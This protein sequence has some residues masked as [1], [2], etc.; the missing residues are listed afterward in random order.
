MSIE[1]ITQQ[2]KDCSNKISEVSDNLSELEKGAKLLG[3]QQLADKLAAEKW[4]L[5]HLP[6][7]MIHISATVTSEVVKITEESSRN[8]IKAAIADSA[9]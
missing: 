8:M 1:Q 2:L 7:I 4:K 6:P 3:M 9:K 5:W